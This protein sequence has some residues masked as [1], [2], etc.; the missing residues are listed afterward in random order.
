MNEKALQY[1]SELHKNPFYW[2]NNKRKIHKYPLL[3]NEVKKEKK[4]LYLEKIFCELSKII[5]DETLTAIN[6]KIDKFVNIKDLRQGDFLWL[7]TT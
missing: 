2:T 6:I 3:R 4:N 7:T 5:E 1:I